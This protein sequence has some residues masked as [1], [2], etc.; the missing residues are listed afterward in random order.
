MNR[1]S[2]PLC[3]GQVLALSSLALTVPLTLAAV[4]DLNGTRLEM[5]MVKVD[6]IENRPPVGVLSATD[7][8]AGRQRQVS[9]LGGRHVGY[10]HALQTT[11]SGFRRLPTAPDDFNNTLPASR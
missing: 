1:E 10:S 3:H 2:G 7:K 4:K 5:G 11:F 8:T 6:H 9:W